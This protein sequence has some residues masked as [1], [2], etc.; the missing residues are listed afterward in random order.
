[1]LTKQIPK[2][3]IE[4]ILKELPEKVDIEEMMY[5]LYLL[6]KIE[7]GEADIHEGRTLSHSEAMKRLS[8][9]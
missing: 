9:K 6:Q 1:M 3:E 5:R 7:A 2:S 8:K 4:K